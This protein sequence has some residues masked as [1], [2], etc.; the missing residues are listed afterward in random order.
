MQQKYRFYTSL[1]HFLDFNFGGGFRGM[2]KSALMGCMS[3]RAAKETTSYW[4]V[5]LPTTSLPQPDHAD[6][7]G[8]EAQFSRQRGAV[9]HKHSHHSIRRRTALLANKTPAKK[10]SLWRDRN[11]SQQYVVI[12]G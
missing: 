9:L 3:H 8:P 10:E 11:L 7:A 6:P 2:R 4:R 1:Y 5:H 12:D